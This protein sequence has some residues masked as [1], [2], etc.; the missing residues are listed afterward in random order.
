MSLRGALTLQRAVIAARAN[1]PDA[2]YDHLEQAGQIA[3]AW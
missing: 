3:G 1:D 2:T